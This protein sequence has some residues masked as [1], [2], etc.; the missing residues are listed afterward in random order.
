VLGLTSAIKEDLVHRM[1]GRGRYAGVTATL[2]LAV[3]L[4]GTSYAA[5]AISSRDIRDGAIR[6]SDLA[7]GSVTSTKVRDGSLLRRDFRS[8]Q[9]PR[10]AGGTGAPGQ[11][12]ARGPQGVAGP[13]GSRGDRGPSGDTGSQG[14][15]GATGAQGAQGD[16]GAQGVAGPEAVPDV[17]LTS[18][19]TP[20]TSTSAVFTSIPSLTQT[21]TVPAGTLRRL[22][23]TFSAE[24][25]CTGT[26]AGKCSL[27]ILVDD[28]Q[29]LPAVGGDFAFDS[30]DNGSEGIA[31][32]DAHSIQRFSANLAAGPHAVTVELSVQGAATSFTVDD[33][34][35]STML[36]AAG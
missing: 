13:K 20:V 30:P 19:P 11:R 25:A 10:R 33:M 16:A 6:A 2:A 32:P 31:S 27:R 28:V 1:F 34:V 9:I 8:D 15:Q 12:G 3:A 23:A 26:G 17:G 4:G 7:T 22:L 21:V 35:L 18:L 5:T 14:A 24:S 36:T 29:L